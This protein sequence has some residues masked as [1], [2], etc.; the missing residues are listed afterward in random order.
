MIE[1]D[2]RTIAAVVRGYVKDRHPDGVTLDVIEA[3]VR[4]IDDWWRVPI[5]PNREPSHT[6]EYY[7][8][9]AEVESRIQE[10]RH[11]NILLV[12]APPDDPVP[13]E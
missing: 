7:D 6:F 5:R 11:L 2:E 1:Q 13:I 9:L 8:A 10:D 12:P 3:G 4:K